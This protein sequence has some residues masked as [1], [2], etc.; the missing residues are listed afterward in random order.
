M[1]S[2]EDWKEIGAIIGGVITGAVASVLG[3]RKLVRKWEKD[4]LEIQKTNAE[5][6]L[7]KS[8]RDE[9][10]RMASQ[11]KKLMEQLSALQ[12]QIGELHSSITKL[13]LENETLT[14]QIFQLHIEV[15][16]ARK[17]SQ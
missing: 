12:L 13:R 9:S 6:S 14:H 10:E 16:K 4:G 1:G 15:D 8:L 7:I 5:E 17:E 11:N 3:S 2:I